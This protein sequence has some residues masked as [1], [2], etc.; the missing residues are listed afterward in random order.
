MPKHMLDKKTVRSNKGSFSELLG[1]ALVICPQENY[2]FSRPS[3]SGMLSV[4]FS[5][6]QRVETAVKANL[7]QNGTFNDI[8]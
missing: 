8:T 2:M 3:A 7:M 5:V 4:T 1:T 6:M